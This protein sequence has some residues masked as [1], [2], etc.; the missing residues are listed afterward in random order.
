MQTALVA[1]S[2]ALFATIMQAN[3][4][5]PH[6]TEPHSVNHPSA[7]ESDPVSGLPVWGWA[8][9]AGSTPM[10]AVTTAEASIATD[11][12]VVRTRNCLLGQSSGLFP[13]ILQQSRILD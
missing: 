9:D 2:N 8:V 11:V 12:R 5:L 3:G 4:S 1:A 13:P 6:P 7:V 10:Q